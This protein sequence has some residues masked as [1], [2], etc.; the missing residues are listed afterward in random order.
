L[1]LKKVRIL[2][3]TSFDSVFPIEFYYH[4]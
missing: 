1:G 2:L 4:L 3:F